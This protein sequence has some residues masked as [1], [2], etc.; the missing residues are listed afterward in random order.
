M[1][2]P[3]PQHPPWV[4][5]ALTV[6]GVSM[7]KKIQES[8]YDFGGM[9][10]HKSIIIVENRHRTNK[11][12]LAFSTVK[13][14]WQFLENNYASHTTDPGLYRAPR[15]KGGTMHTKITYRWFRQAMLDVKR[16]LDDEV[17][18]CAKH[19]DPLA[20]VTTIPYYQKKHKNKEMKE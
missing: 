3:P 18:I 19:G 20:F 5:A 14:T 9:A 4:K 1:A 16:G 11:S 2:Q 12:R 17:S 6:Q 15:K 13:A 10:R 8:K 7:G